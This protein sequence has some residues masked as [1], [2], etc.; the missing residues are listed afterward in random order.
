LIDVPRRIKSDLERLCCVE[1]ARQ[2]T[3]SLAIRD[4]YGDII[5]KQPPSDG[6]ATTCHWCRARLVFIESEYCWYTVKER[7]VNGVLH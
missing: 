3:Q 1:S 4:D 6:E 5:S 7:E 2:Y